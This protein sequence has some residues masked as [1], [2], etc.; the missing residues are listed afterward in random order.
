MQ[1]N[2]ILRSFLVVSRW[3]IQLVS[4]ASATLGPILAASKIG[5]LFSADVLLFILLFYLAATFSC[6]IN[7]YY[8]VDVD[9]L[10]KK[11]LSSAVETIGKP[12]LRAIMLA[13]LILAAIISSVLALH[14]RIITSLL[15]LSGLLFG[16]AYS[17]PPLRMKG[18]GLWGQLLVNTGIYVFPILGGY[19]VVKNWIPLNIWL[20][21]I[22][23]AVM[24][25]GINLVNS[26]EDYD[27]DRRMGIR[28]AAHALG[29]KRTLYLAALLML[30]GY[31]SLIA[32][33]G[34]FYHTGSWLAL[35]GLT[36]LAWSAGRFAVD[37][38]RGIFLGKKEM[39]QRA[40]DCGAKVPKW[41]VITR[42]PIWLFLLLCLI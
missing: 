8:D 5:D 19:L 11:R 10:Y 16:W 33:V 13:E 4:F 27:E 7:C 29:L 31:F 26:A 23:Y 41:F 1:K 24:N 18:H 22:F 17:S 2:S 3:E 6:N 37:V 32:L 28:T 21:V 30:A 12:G 40:K 42:Y 35:A 39:Q 9:S 36:V 38:I 25:T 20:F 15:A 14:G 34:T